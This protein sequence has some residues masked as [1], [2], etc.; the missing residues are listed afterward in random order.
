MLSSPPARGATL[1]SAGAC[2]LGGGFAAVGFVS[3]NFEGFCEAVDSLG[4]GDLLV[5]D[6]EGEG[7]GMN[8]DD[9]WGNLHVLLNPGLPRLN[10]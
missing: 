10:G 9:N 6:V 5:P 3:V 1:F 8:Y 4:G 2:S 7:R